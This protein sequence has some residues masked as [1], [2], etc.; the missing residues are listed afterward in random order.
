MVAVVGR[1]GTP[2]MTASGANER[3]PASPEKQLRRMRCPLLMTRTPP[4]LGFPLP[5]KRFSSTVLRSP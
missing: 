3:R 4:V 5:M 2:S 1:V